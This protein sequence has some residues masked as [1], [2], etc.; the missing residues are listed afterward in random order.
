[1]GVGEVQFKMSTDNIAMVNVPKHLM[2]WVCGFLASPSR[3]STVKE[4]PGTHLI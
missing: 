2:P 3:G 1:M 4:L